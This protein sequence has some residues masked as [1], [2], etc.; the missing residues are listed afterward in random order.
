METLF[1]KHDRLLAI[2]PTTMI[3][4]M[5]SQI[6]WE[7]PLIAI[8]GARGVGK[9]TLLLQ[10]AKLNF[11]P[12][13]REVLYCAMDSIYFSSHSLLQLAEQFFQEGGKLLLLCF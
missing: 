8:R 3:R 12:Y 10:Y 6:N 2:T 9:S 7:A 11:A 13:S 1:K 5:M 4:G